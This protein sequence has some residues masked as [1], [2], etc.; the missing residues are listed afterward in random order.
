V[1]EEASNLFFHA[2]NGPLRF[3]ASAI[4]ALQEATEQYL[5]SLFEETGLCAFHANRVTI[6]PKDMQ[7]ALRLGRRV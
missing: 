2:A 6:I 1:R 7:L 3:Q 5:V 4:I